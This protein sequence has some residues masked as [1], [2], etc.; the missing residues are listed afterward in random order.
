MKQKERR[1]NA[2]GF[3]FMTLGLI[4][5]LVIF[6]L[7]AMTKVVNRKVILSG[8]LILILASFVPAIAEVFNSM[9]QAVLGGCTI[10]MFGNIILS[11]FQMI[12]EAGFTQRNITIAALSLTIGIGFTQVSDIFVHFPALLQSVFVGNSVALVFLVA[13]VLSLVGVSAPQVM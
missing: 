13:L 11:G 10:M 3:D 4:F 8:G 6:G 2:R 9:P 7:V 12:A 1:L 5:V